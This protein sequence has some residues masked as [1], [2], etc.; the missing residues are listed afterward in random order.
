MVA[1]DGRHPFWISFIDSLLIFP[2][3]MCHFDSVVFLGAESR[4]SSFHP[5]MKCFALVSWSLS[6]RSFFTKNA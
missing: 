4:H 3:W 6:I 1:Y 2:I 5:D